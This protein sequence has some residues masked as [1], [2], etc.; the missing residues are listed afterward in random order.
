MMNGSSRPEGSKWRITPVALFTLCLLAGFGGTSGGDQR[1]LRLHGTSVTVRGRVRNGG[2]RETIGGSKLT[3]YAVGSSGYGTGATPIANATADSDGFFALGPFDCPSGNPQTYVIATGGKVT[4]GTVSRDNPAIGL[5]AMSGPCDSLND[6]TFVALNPLTTVATQWALAQFIDSTG[7]QIGA[8]STNAK[9]LANQINQL[10]TNLVVSVG[11]DEQDSGIRADFLREMS[12]YD[13]KVRNCDGLERLD[14]LANV[15]ATCIGSPTRYLDKCPEL[16]CLATPGADFSPVPGCTKTPTSA[17]TLDAAHSI[18]TNPANNVTAIYLFASPDFDRFT[19]I[20]RTPPLEWVLAL[21]FDPEVDTLQASD[22]AIDAEGNVWIVNHGKSSITELNP[23][24][25]LIGDFKIQHGTAYDR[26]PVQMA[27][28]VSGNAWVVSQ[29]ENH[30]TKLDSKGVVIGSFDPSDALNHPYG[31]AADAGGNVWVANEDDNGVVK[32]APDGTLAGNFKPAGARFN[33]PFGVALDSS[34]YVWITNHG[35]NSVTKLTLSGDA[36]GNFDAHLER[37]RNLALDAAGN[38]WIVNLDQM[39]ELNSSGGF[40]KLIPRSTFFGPPVDI[41]ID[42]SE[43]VWYVTQRDRLG[44]A[45]FPFNSPPDFSSFYPLG[46]AFHQPEALAIDGAGNIWVANRLSL[47]R[48]FVSEVI[49]AAPPV[50]TPQVAC[51]KKSPAATVCR[52]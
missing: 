50:L 18:V 24:G 39:S 5:M 36:N 16:F 30:V 3:L 35:D 2:S 48:R 7:R 44:E 28:D 27:F 37:P 17:D 15:I 22:V 43:N 21:N 4:A 32:L 34:G 13:P 11:K 1:P 38:V 8:S 52:P 40:A 42:S 14:T 46:A 9:G 49:G 25:R 19:P 10:T 41:A 12:C 31:V 51:L 45:K 33:K 47:D 20:L 6:S 26:G 29:A 23:N